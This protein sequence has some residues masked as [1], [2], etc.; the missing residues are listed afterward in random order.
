MKVISIKIE[1]LLSQ[2]CNI[3]ENVIPL[4]ERLAELPHQIRPTLHQKMLIDNHTDG[5]KSKT[6][7]YLKLEDNFGFCKSLKKLTKILGFHMML[8]TNDLQDIIYTSM[9]D[10]KNVTINSV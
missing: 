5:S 9:D 4:F 1:D 7:E 6:K 3:N 10:D 2:F 8:K